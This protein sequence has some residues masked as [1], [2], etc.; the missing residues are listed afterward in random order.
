[1]PP[2]SEVATGP[3]LSEDLQ[4]N[5]AAVGVLADIGELILIALPYDGTVAGEFLVALFDVGATFANC[6]SV[7]EC[8]VGQP[9]P[10]LPSMLV[11][12]QSVLVNTVDLMAS[13]TVILDA[14]SA[15]GS[16]AHDI[17][18][19]KGAIQ[20]YVSVGITTELGLS[21]VIAGTPYRMYLL[22][23]SYNDSE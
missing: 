19:L 20:N 10:D 17:G 22:V 23:Y 9:H 15:T 1:M 6:I 13:W 7:G 16:L 8:Y 18:I 5:T 12:N 14:V 2:G 21:S 11:V 3:Q 4:D